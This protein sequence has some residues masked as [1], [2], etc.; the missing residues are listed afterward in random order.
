MWKQ[1]STA[2]QSMYDDVV[3]GKEEYC[4]CVDCK[5]DPCECG[6][7]REGMGPEG[8]GHKTSDAESLGNKKK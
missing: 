3:Q 1:L 8:G 6:D 5:R 7:W 4:D 2:Y